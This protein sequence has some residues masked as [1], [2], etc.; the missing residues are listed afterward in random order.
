[1]H[2]SFHLI[3]QACEKG[4]SVASVHVQLSI[5]LTTRVQGH[6]LQLHSRVR[7]LIRIAVVDLGHEFLHA[8]RQYRCK[9]RG[10]GSCWER[11]RGSACVP[12]AVAANM[13]AFLPEPPT[14][15]RKIKTCKYRRT[16]DTH[17]D[18][19]APETDPAES[20]QQAVTAPCCP[21]VAACRRSC[22]AARRQSEPRVTHL[23]LTLHCGSNLSRCTSLRYSS[24]HAHCNDANHRGLAFFDTLFV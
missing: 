19:E 16:R 24:N 5:H 3:A 13:C 17:R 2:A 4:H 12:R 11:K 10:K 15:S 8:N 6:S 18:Q 7:F 23:R 1:M 22:A 9:C 20:R 14:Y 21:F